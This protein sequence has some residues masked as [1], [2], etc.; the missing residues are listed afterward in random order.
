MPAVGREPRGTLF[1]DVTYP[2]K[3]LDILLERWAAEQPDLGHIRRTMPRQ[4]ALAF[5]RF[6]HRGFFAAD[7]GAGTSPQMNARAAGQARL[8]HPRDLLL[9]HEAQFAIF[10][11]HVEIDVARL[12]HP[13]GDQHAFDEAVGIALEVMAVLEC[14][15]LA[16]VGI[17]RHESRRGFGTHD[18]PFAPGGKARATEPAQPRVAYDLDDFIARARSRLARPQQPVAAGA[19]VAIKRHRGRISLRVRPMGY[20]CRHALDVCMLHLGMTDSADRRAIAGP[21]AR[22]ADDAHVAP[23]PVRKLAP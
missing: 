13:G 22:C 23:E 10:V 18:R 6:D 15:G 21:H 20:R 1:D 17:D 5:D 11:A 2:I 12:D 14:A 7:I 16:F 8:H 19:N 3:R 9:E 4:T